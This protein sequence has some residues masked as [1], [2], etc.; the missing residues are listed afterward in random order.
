MPRL[1]ILV[2]GM[3]VHPPGW[4][5]DIQAKLDEAASQFDFF[6][7][8]PL[9]SQVTFAEVDYDDVFV[10]QVT[11]FGMTAKELKDFGKSKKVD[12]SDT[13]TWLEGASAEE[14]SFFWSHCDDVLLYHFFRSVRKSVQA[15]V[16]DQIATAIKTAREE[17]PTSVT[18]VAHSLGTAVTH[19]ALATLG[20]QPWK[21]SQAFMAG[22][23]QIESLFMIANVSRCL[24]TDNLTDTSCVF[25]GTLAKGAYTE[26]YFNVRH[27]LDPVPAVRPFAPGASWS[28]K[29]YLA[30]DSLDHLLDLNV[31]D[32]RHYLDHPL[33]HIPLIRRMFG[34]DAVTPE[35]ETRVT[36][37]YP[38][39]AAPPCPDRVRVMRDKYRQMVDLLRGNN[40]PVALIIAAAQFFASAKEA[41][42][43]CTGA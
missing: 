12:V 20:A 16:R 5:T 27:T 1:V 11:D 30:I 3:G 23:F 32:F 34:G 17:G 38:L 10:K 28:A 35:E 13:V 6:N 21:G 9:K 26:A 7:G 42:D 39:K 37:L 36:K 33:V 15:R 31:H 19:D 4:S 25:P 14:K 40:N 22:T 41:K 24:E 43:A 29:R 8:N 18:V 2:H